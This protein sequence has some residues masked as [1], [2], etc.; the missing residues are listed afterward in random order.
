MMLSRLRRYLAGLNDDERGS[1]ALQII[2]LIAIAGVCLVLVKLW[3]N[4]YFE[5][6]RQ[7]VEIFVEN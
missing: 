2:M 5:Y 6:V 4:W 7:A 3:G 1:E